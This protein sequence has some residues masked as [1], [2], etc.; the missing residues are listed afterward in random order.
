MRNVIRKFY[1]II[2]VA[3]LVVA[4]GLF[5]QFN[6]FNNAWLKETQI[7][8]EESRDTIGSKISSNL[9]D[10]GQIINVVAEYI[11]LEKWN[12]ENLLAYLKGLLKNNPELSSIYFGSVNNEMINGSGWI[13]PR[14]FDLRSRPWYIK[15]VKEKKLVFSEAFVNAS[16]DK[17][18]ITIAKPVYNSKN[19]LLGVIAGDVSLK[20][21]ISIVEDKKVMEN[22]YSFLIDGKGNIIAHPKYE[23]NLNLKLKNIKELSKELSGVLLQ[24]KPGITKISLDGI[25]GYLAYQSIGN[26]DWK[27]GSFMP[28]DSYVKINTEYLRMFLIILLSSLVLFALFIM[29]QK[30]YIIKPMLS[31]DD[32]IQKINHEE[33]IGY[34]LP[35]EEKEVFAVLRKSINTTL[36][37]TQGLFEQIELEEEELRATN[38]E[39]EATVQQLS[40]AEEELRNQYDQIIDSEYTFRTLFEGSS[41]PILIMDGNK[42]IDCNPAMIELLGY[43]SKE[44]VVAKLIWDI[45]PELQPD[46]QL[47]KDKANEI[48]DNIQNKKS[49]FEWWHIK[50]NEQTLPVEVMLTTI[51]LNGKKVFHALLRD[52]SERKQMEMKLE[53]LSYHDQLT[54][55]YN[56]RYFEEELKRLDVQR[57]LPLTIVMADVNGLKLINDSF[58]HAVGDELLKKV[59]EVMKKGFRA[60]DI[61]ARLGG[62]EFVVLLPKIDNYDTEQI[63]KRIKAFALKENVGSIGISIS[64]GWETK[65][66]NDENVQEVLKKAEDH[67]YKKK[68]FDS[69]SMRGKTINAIISTLHEKN[70][71]EE[72]HSHR[73][74]TLCKSMGKALNMSESEIQE[75]KSVG[76]L[77]DIGKIAIEENI[78]N[79]P[80]KLTDGEWEE[81]KRH[82]EIGYRI[83]ST[84][85]DMSEMSEYVLAHHERWDGNGYPKGLK[86][87]KIPLQSRIIS[88]VDTYDAMTSERSYRKALPEETA[89]EEL[90]KNSGSQF[91]PKLVMLFIEK[92]LSKTS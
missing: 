86:G 9:L 66:N 69:P 63:V 85:N 80:S 34:R 87:E 36:S 54:G 55:L 82:P 56:R 49:K 3:V 75:L 16:K 26:T 25:S 40:A 1:R 22:G 2:A 76:L 8:T 41:D 24:N 23:Y 28:L 88:I 72:A 33:D 48:I 47:S 67:M 27:I 17:L 39:L 77:H 58:G 81:I 92:V 5:F 91:D 61:I 71:R 79:K 30:R 21:I 84:V 6:Y 70:K 83:L 74:S 46:G 51:L 37:K 14:T 32:D 45:S 68:L 13:P 12:K 78:L 60:D 90:R 19:Q 57:N 18:I 35:V 50:N 62:D 53:Y 65:N 44:S 10:K 52:I 20:D 7:L 73:V 43:P 4:L 59:S 29:H 11:S 38:E 64:F 42:I 31:L 89:L 15:A